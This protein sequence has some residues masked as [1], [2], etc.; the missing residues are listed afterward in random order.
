MTTVEDA[1]KTNKKFCNNCKDKNYLIECKCGCGEIKFLRD[2]QG[3]IRL[4]I[5]GHRVRIMDQSGE[6]HWN[7][8]GGRTKQGNYWFLYLP[9]YFSSNKHNYVRE[10][11]YFYQE[12]HKCC[13]LSWG[14]IHH[15]EPV[16]KDYCNNMIWNLLGVTTR[17]HQF[18]HHI[19]KRY[20]IKDHSK[21]F[22]LICDSKE[23][24]IQKIN[25]RPDW[26]K[27]KDGYIC[28]KCYDKI[29]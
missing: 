7:W 8:K 27:Y 18:I 12:F 25:G 16:T 10:H 23:T 29:K 20:I 4:F 21:T 24:Y 17:Q 2:K 13:M 26:R 15:I 22:C 1:I 19:G 14:E 9:G 5:H 11:V 28:R 3:V 6:D